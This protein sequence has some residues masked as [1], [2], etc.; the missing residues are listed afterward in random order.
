MENSCLYSE[1]LLEHH[2]GEYP[3]YL[4]VGDPPRA[5]A[6]LLLQH[7]D[8]GP[9]GT[10]SLGCG[11]LLGFDQSDTVA[12]I[13]PTVSTVQDVWT[14]APLVCFVHSARWGGILSEI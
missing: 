3:G 14:G 11:G 7:C 9:A 2:L 8:E 4:R 12:Q 10:S 13:G 1:I 5:V 6:E